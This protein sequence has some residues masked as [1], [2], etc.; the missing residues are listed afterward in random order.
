[1]TETLLSQIETQWKPIQENIAAYGVTDRST[2][3][4]L[5]EMYKH[6]EA[7]LQLT[8]DP[9]EKSGLEFVSRQVRAVLGVGTAA[10]PSSALLPEQGA[11]QQGQFHVPNIKTEF[12]T[13]RDAVLQQLHDALQTGGNTASIQALSGMGGGGKTQTALQYAERFEREYEWVLWTRADSADELRQG[14]AALTVPLGLPEQN[15]PNRNTQTAA[16]VKWLQTHPNWLLICDNADFSET[17]TPAD[18]KA[19]LPANYTGHLLLTSRSN[20]FGTLGIPKPIRLD[21]MTVKEADDFLWKRV[22]RSRTE[23]TPAEQEAA[24]QIVEELGYLPLALEQAGAYIG[25]QEK[26]FAS[27]LNEYRANAKRLLQKSAPEFGV[28]YRAA[29]AGEYH[30]VWT[31]WDL[32]FAAVKQESEA[33]AHLLTFSAFLADAS[34]PA[35]LLIK[36]AHHLGDELAA[37]F[38]KAEHSEAVYDELLEPLTRYSLVRKEIERET[39]TMHR[40]VQAV[41]RDRLSAEEQ[42]Q[43]RERVV[44][45]VYAAFPRGYFETWA[46]CE[47]LL[48]HGRLCAKYIE[49]YEFNLPEAASLLN[50]MGYYLYNRAQYTDAERLLQQALQ[51]YVHMKAPENSHLVYSLN[52]LAILYQQQGRYAEAEPLLR[53]ALEIN[54]QAFGQED[55]AT[56]HT[57]HNLAVLYAEQARYDEAEPLYQ[58]ALALR[59]KVLPPEHPALASS[60]N[61]L[62]DLYWKQERYAEA[63]PLL[64]KALYINER[65]FGPEHPN[66]AVTFNNLATL[67]KSQGQYERAELLYKQALALR[68]KLLPSKHPDIASTLYNLAGLYYRQERYEEA[69]PLTQET[70]QIFCAAFGE[71][72]PRVADAYEKQA[73]VLRSLNREEEAQ[74][75]DAKADAI[76][77]E[78]ARRE[79]K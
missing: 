8:S 26:R 45:A 31:I 54:Q 59:R 24:S 58:Q 27:Y 66:V 61:H 51:I 22:G 56:A 67:C 41:L 72:H 64:Q 44:L 6:L 20:Y 38:V 50:N 11:K 5:G 78:L 73:D 35:E 52:N 75:I 4:Q 60:L 7:A 48:P 3:R 1:M 29:D 69:L 65:V 40:L 77:A 43:W 71:T 28:Y 53:Q 55:S 46:E 68:R 49:Q 15:A 57:L 70:L 42:E 23:A 2:M 39:Y 33:S 14:L 21:A 30:T 17:W 19:I 63:E 25:A 62:A 12:F 32:N 79:G 34:I 47:R 74:E 9:Q 16:T 13:G 10:N 36:G 18:F 37:V 76:R